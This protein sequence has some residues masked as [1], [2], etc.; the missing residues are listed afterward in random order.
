MLKIKMLLLC[1]L[2][3]LTLFSCDSDSDNGDVKSVIEKDG[4]VNVEFQTRF[5]NGVTVL[6][7]KQTVFVEGKSVKFTLKLDTIPNL[8]DTLTVFENEDS[9]WNARVRKQYKF[10]ITLK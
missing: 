2:L 5:E 1:G 10:F 8:R 3:S 9:T 6:T 4:S 7:T